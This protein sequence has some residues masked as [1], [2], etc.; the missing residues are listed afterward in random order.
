M[1]WA[2][3]PLREEIASSV[4]KIKQRKV[5]GGS[6]N[7]H[8]PSPCTQRGAESRPGL[9]EGI[10]GWV[11]VGSSTRSA[12]APAA[13]LPSRVAPVPPQRVP[14]SPGRKLLTQVLRGKHGTGAAAGHSQP[15][16]LHPHSSGAWGHL[17]GRP[18]PLPV[19]GL[20]GAAASTRLALCLARVQVVKARCQS[21]QRGWKHGKHDSPARLHGSPGCPPRAWVPAACSPALSLPAGCPGSAV[22]AG[23]RLA[24]PGLPGLRCGTGAAGPSAA[25]RPS[26]EARSKAP[27]PPR[28]E[29]GRCGSSV[30]SPVSS[31]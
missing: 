3:F 17:P 29:L 11:P 27:L 2:W 8:A 24:A 19:W 14:C 16:A 28:D 12:R 10:P 15:L 5:K 25:A 7:P 9:D 21:L 30:L 20:A 6:I 23:K 26:T 31:R 1:S 13:L 18:A 4:R 22:A